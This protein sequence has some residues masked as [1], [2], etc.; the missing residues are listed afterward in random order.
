MRKDLGICALMILCVAIDC[1]GRFAALSL[2]LPMWLDTA[3]TMLAA[4]ALGPA[5]GAMAGG[6]FSLI[7][8]DLSG[9]P[10]EL[11][12]AATSIAI[13]IIAGQASRRGAFG[14]LFGALSLAFIVAPAATA[15]STPLNFLASGGMTGNQWGDG[16]IVLMT[17]NG[18]NQAL[19]CII[20]QFYLEFPDKVASVLLLYA[21]LRLH[22]LQKRIF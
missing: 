2:D 7:F 13:G 4:Y 16:I 11:C 9:N 14:S 19:S 3:G 21:A 20:G 6:T 1:A 18:A 12:Y 10:L 15:I 8:S 17:E 22:L 5:C